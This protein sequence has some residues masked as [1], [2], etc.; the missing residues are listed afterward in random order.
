MKIIV[1]GAT[2]FI[3]NH[4][5][6]YLLG[7]KVNLYV[8]STNS[9]KARQQDWFS[10]VKYL[11]FSIGDELDETA[12]LFFQ[13]ADIVIHLAWS[14][15]PDFKSEKHIQF[16]LAQ[17]LKFISQLMHLNIRR[18]VNIGTCLEYG[19]Q[20]GELHEEMPVSPIVNYAIAKNELRLFTEQN[21][22]YFNEGTC[23]I[24]LFYVFGE[25]QSKKSL[26]PQ[27]HQAISEQK[28]SFDMS[29]GEQERDYLPVGKVAEYIVRIAFE[30]SAQGIFNCSSGKPI[31]IRTF[32]EDFIQKMEANIKL[33]FGVYPYPDYEPVQ[34]WGRNVKLR[35]VLNI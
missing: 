30:K 11:A 26:I 6:R 33:N 21:S 29:D 23:W 22:T 5:I 19:L 10:K 4:V 32:A 9:E 24:R 16:Y 12:S 18:L 31:K 8:T 35:T 3:G 20:E 34:F 1:T 7:Q 28:P 27:L 25:G 14:G 17:Q 2:G 13:D 15:L